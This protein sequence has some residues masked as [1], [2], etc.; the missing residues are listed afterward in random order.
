MAAASSSD[1]TQCSLVERTREVLSLEQALSAV[2]PAVSVMEWPP[3]AARSLVSQH[4]MRPSHQDQDKLV[5]GKFPAHKSLTSVEVSLLA[6]PVSSEVLE[7]VQAQLS[8]A[9]AEWVGHLMILTPT[10]T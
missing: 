7:L 4:K 8:V 10:S 1:R 3:Q 9:R 2:G 5:V 6:L